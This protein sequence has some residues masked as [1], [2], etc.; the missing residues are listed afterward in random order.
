[1]AD[2]YKEGNCLVSFLGHLLRDDIINP[3]KM[4]VRMYVHLYVHLYVRMSTMKQNAATNQIVV[5]VR[6]DETFTMI[7]LSRSSEVRV[8]VVRLKVSKMTIFK[9]YLLH[10]FSTS[11][12]IQMV[13]DTRPK[14]LKSQARFFSFLLV[15]ES[16][17]FKLCK[18]IDFIRS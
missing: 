18:N 11:Q 5:F 6:V 8:K 17:D 3:V 1:L 16:S 15:I 12:K 9:I 7:W 13:S 2:V 14:Y 4:P 10:H